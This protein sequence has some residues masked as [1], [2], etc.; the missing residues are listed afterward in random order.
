M[1]RYFSA[2]AIPLALLDVGSGMAGRR[3]PGRIGVT[4]VASS[5]KT[6]LGP[7]VYGG[8]FA[9][10]GA[11]RSVVAVMF[12]FGSAPTAMVGYTMA[13]AMGCDAETA[14][15][16]ILVSTLMSAFTMAASITILRVIG[17]A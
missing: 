10:A 4:L 11:D 14:G 3:K 8:L 5:I 15:D 9:L 16:I 1:V 2:M 6:V 17:F 7:V 12:L 13:K